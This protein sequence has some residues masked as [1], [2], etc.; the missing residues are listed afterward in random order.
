MIALW[1]Y[2]YFD[3]LPSEIMYIWCQ[4]ISWTSI[5]FIV[6]RYTLL[7]YLLVRVAML[8]NNHMPNTL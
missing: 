1:F 3:T 6:N 7:V 8:A 5:L 2:D 4:E